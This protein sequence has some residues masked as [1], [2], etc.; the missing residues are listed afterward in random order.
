MEKLNLCYLMIE[1]LIMKLAMELIGDNGDKKRL[2]VIGKKRPN[3]NVQLVLFE[4]FSF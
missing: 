4:L 2:S 1:L 3:E